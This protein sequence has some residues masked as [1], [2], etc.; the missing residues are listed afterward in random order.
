MRWLVG[1]SSTVVT[2]CAWGSAPSTPQHSIVIIICLF[3]THQGHH[4]VVTTH[5]SSLDGVPGLSLHTIQ[6]SSTV[7]SG[8][9]L[10]IR[11]HLATGRV[12]RNG[13][14][15]GVS[16]DPWGEYCGLLGW[17][18]PLAGVPL[19]SGSVWAPPPPLVLGTAVPSA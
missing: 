14:D 13:H 18:L 10:T 6:L 8:Q 11:W 9:G 3:E 4:L 7:V 16:M 2:I 15:R 17:V 19:A 12:Q 5:S 1:S